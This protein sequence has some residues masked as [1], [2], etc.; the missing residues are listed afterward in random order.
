MLTTGITALLG[1]IF[2][3]ICSRFFT[4]DQIGIATSLISAM[5]LISYMS[6]LGFNNTFIRTLPTSTNRN[7]VINTG[8][9]LSIIASIVVSILYLSSLDIIAPKLRPELNTLF[10]DIGFVLLVTLSTTNLLTDSIFVAFR[11]AKYNLLIDGFVQGI[12][13]LAL[14]I[15]LV[16]LGSYGIFLA[17]GAAASIAMIASITFLILRFEYKPKLFIHIQ[18]LRNLFN[19]SFVNYIANIFNIAPTLI[20]PLIVLNHLGAASAGYYYLAFTIANLLYAVV[21]AVSSSLFAEGSYAEESL[22]D[23]V[24]KSTKIVA[25]L[26]IP[27]TIILIIFGPTVLKIFGKTY[28]DSARDIIR[29]LALSS[30]A[31]AAYTLGNIILRIFHKVEA[32]ITVNLIYMVSISTLAYMWVDHGLYAVGYAWMAGNIIASIYAFKSIY[33]SRH[34]LV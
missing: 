25:I 27:S 18:T 30:P 15:V 23:L 13:K 26:I 29:I 2:W 32:I 14:P 7:N 21:Y 12:I 3:I 19:Y 22:K 31:V 8:L 28:S 9:I 10:H 16:F 5:S 1:F 34:H 11:G 20:L 6:L 17:S 33:N 4:P 24:V